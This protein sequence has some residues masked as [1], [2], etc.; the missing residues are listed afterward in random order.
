MRRSRDM[1]AGGRLRSWWWSRLAHLSG[2]QRRGVM[3]ASQATAEGAR[4]LETEFL[5]RHRLIGIELGHGG[6]RRCAM[7]A[8][9][10]RRRTRFQNRRLIRPALQLFH[11]AEHR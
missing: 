4:E 1:N 6:A 2:T 5:G 8:S 7:S 10:A 11:S 9:L 3:L